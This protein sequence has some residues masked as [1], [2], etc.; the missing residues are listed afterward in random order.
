MWLQSTANNLSLWRYFRSCLWTWHTARNSVFRSGKPQ[1][2]WCFLK[3]AISVCFLF[4]VRSQ[5]WFCIVPFLSVANVSWKWDVLSNLDERTWPVI[6]KRIDFSSCSYIK[7]NENKTFF[8]YLLASPDNPAVH[9][10]PGE[11]PVYSW[12]GPPHIGCVSAV[13]CSAGLRS[14]RG[15][16]GRVLS[17]GL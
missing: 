5:W 15:Q 12:T 10:D 7:I 8:F 3:Q 11:P 2:T 1:G 14:I 4:F 17:A 16:S 6:L 9:G 13:L